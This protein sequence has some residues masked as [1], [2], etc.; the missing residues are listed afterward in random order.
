[1]PMW[2]GIDEA[3]YGP[4]LGPLV[5]AGSAFVTREPPCEGVLWELLREGVAKSPRGSA[6]RLV[7]ND[8]K[9]VYSGPAGLRR[10]APRRR[11]STP[12]STRPRCRR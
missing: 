10:P 12:R 8:S 2:A 6:G 5:V 1:M 9:V 3:G 4:A 11:G 7:V